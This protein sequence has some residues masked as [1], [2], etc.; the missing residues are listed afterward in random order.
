M[1]TFLNK[2]SQYIASLVDYILDTKPYHS[3]LT[4]IVEEYQ[5]FDSM[6]VHFEEKTNI[7][8][9]IDPAWMYNFFSSGDS[10]L[11]S[12]GVKQ[13]EYPSTT[14][15]P[16]NASPSY[17]GAIKANRD[18]NTDFA[19]I[20]YVYS[21]KAFDGVGVADLLIE[22]N[23]NR[24]TMEPLVEGLDFF[25]SHGSMQLQIKQTTDAGS[26]FVPSWAETRDENVISTATALTKQFAEDTGNPYSAVNQVK[27]LLLQIQALP[28]L[29]PAAIT[30]LN[31]LFTIVA[32]PKL[33]QDYEPL[34]NQLVADGTPVLAG[35]IGW[36][37]QDTTSTTYV[38]ERFSQLSPSMYFNM[39]SDADV[40]ESGQA[41][42]DDVMTSILNI[43]S[44]TVTGL[45]VPGD[46]WSVVAQDDA[47]PLYA[48]FSSINGYIGSFTATVGGTLFST[49]TISFRA[50]FVSQP[51]TGDSVTIKNRNRLVFGPS[52]PLEKWDIIKINPIAYT[53]PVLVSTRYGYI[54]DQFG[55]QG[56]VTLIDPALPTGTIILTARADGLTFDLTS[57]VE[58][59]YTGVATA[60]V[61]FNDGRI[62]F[63]I[64]TGSAQPFTLGDKFYIDVLNAPA[65]A[66]DLD[67]GYGYDLDAYDNQHLEYDNSQPAGTKLNFVYDT[68]FTDYNLANLNLT[69]GQNAISG[70]KWRITAIPNLSK[71][72]ATIKKDGSGPSNSVDVQDATDGLA[73]DPALNA[74]PIYELIGEPTNGVPDLKLYYA[75]FFRVEYSDNDFNTIVS[76]GTVAVGATFTNVIQDISF[77]IVQ[78]SKPFIAVQSDDGPN[79]L[80]EGGDVFSFGVLNAPP[81]LNEAPVGLTSASIARLIMNGDGFHEAPPAQWVVTFGSSIAYTVSGILTEGTP[82]FQVPGGPLSG[83]LTTPGTSALEGNSFNRLGVHFTVVPGNAGLGAGDY[84]TFTTFSRKP[85]YLVHGSA[86]GW[87]DPAVVGETYWNGTIGFTI[88]KPT[89]ELFNHAAA[90]PRYVPVSENTW[91]LGTGQLQ[92]MRLRFDAPNLIYTLTPTPIGSGTPTGWYVT[93]SDI[94]A[95][96]YLSQTGSFTDTYITIDTLVNVPSAEVVKLQLEI[97]ADDFVLWNNQDSV[98]LHPVISARLPASTD[99]VLIDKRTQDRLALNLDYSS[100]ATPPSLAALAPE[101][102][103][104]HF[105]DTYTGPGGLPL[106]TWSPETGVI[107]NWV[108]LTMVARD[109][110]TSVAEFSDVA[111]A[112]DVYAAGSGEPVGTLEPTGTNDLW[113]VSFTW[114]LNFFGTYLPLNTGSNLVTYGSGF[115]E[116]LHAR[117]SESVKFLVSGGALTTDFLFHDD[118]TVV[119][120]EHNAWTIFQTEQDSITANVDDGPFG[121]FL[122]GYDTLRYDQE[123]DP[124]GYFGIGTPLTD[125]FLE[126]QQLAGITPL[127]ARQA[128]LTLAQ[129]T[130]RLS[131]LIG[132]LDGYL[133]AGG[134]ASTTLPQFLAAIDA[135]DTI[136]FTPANGN[137]VSFPTFGI[138]A[139]GMAMDITIGQAGANANNPATEGVTNQVLD[140]LVVMA[141]DTAYTYDSFGFDVGGL[142]SLADRT[143]IVYAGAVPPIPTPLP[144]F[145]T[146]AEFETPL[147]IVGD[148]SMPADFTARVFE[149]D[150]RVTTANLAY[151]QSLQPASTP[152]PPSGQLRVFIWFPGQSLPQQVSV[153]EKIGTGKFRFSVPAATEAK[154]YL[155]LVP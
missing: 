46:T 107:S 49:S 92:L 2:N 82:G 52:A 80:V 10:T 28:G 148:E 6:N 106:T 96:G 36:V 65:V 58:P 73:P 136:N 116:L 138:P 74:A 64:K 56:Q 154:L 47:V 97:T 69:I 27:N 30:A 43:L 122:P 37:G 129:R 131:T 17:P 25:Q 42:Y 147:A 146:Y 105:I 71:P 124:N 18:E 112:F 103:D 117:I 20:P 100:V 55:V 93:R 126:A 149:L 143:A 53:R 125:Y 23:G 128:A 21:K 24:S 108:P 29:S 141:I 88:E 110:D 54:Q 155:D 102:I 142:D 57:T 98:I 140:A 120:D 130:N 86:T 81:I 14:V 85:S 152:A 101:T 5:F 90:E 94:G 40:R 15:F 115:N 70:R 32:I 67:L 41:A 48:V 145:T 113:P 60:N 16:S 66:I 34:L 33:P 134:I 135:D 114:D 75:D 87:T 9:K 72:I 119:V 50:A 62:A 127:T 4:E 139:L 76:L 38:S 95:V 39:F 51:V 78:G 121:G 35:Y 31:D 26:N 7:Q 137:G 13:L 83:T 153:V 151:M 45:A 118:I 11:R 63:T 22:R 44:I 123:N 109:S 133:Q 19:N 8:I 132:L 77:T 99:F 79:P 144:A 84:F 104:V 89:A 111:K 59:L 91:S 68:R 61:L 12:F 1:A 150:F 3:K